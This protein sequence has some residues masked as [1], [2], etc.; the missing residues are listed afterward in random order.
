M[1]EGPQTLVCISLPSLS[2]QL[3][4]WTL[5]LRR[6]PIFTKS[7][8][9]HGAMTQVQCYTSDHAFHQYVMNC[10]NSDMGQ[11]DMEIFH[12]KLFISFHSCCSYSHF[13]FCRAI[14]DFDLT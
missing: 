3:G 12:G 14:C 1:D 11:T 10:P 9:A 5:L 2:N 13:A 7:T 4:S 6:L 8:L